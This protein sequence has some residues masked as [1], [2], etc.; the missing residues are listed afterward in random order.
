VTP[1]RAELRAAPLPVE[2]S[3]YDIG[4]AAGTVAGVSQRWS[5]MLVGLDD[6]PG[7]ALFAMEQLGE[8]LRAAGGN[9]SDLQALS[10]EPYLQLRELGKVHGDR[11]NLVEVLGVEHPLAE[12]TAATDRLLSLAGRAVADQFSSPQEGKVVRLGVS[13]G[14]VPKKSTST[15]EIGLRGMADDVQ[16]DRRNHGRPFQAVCLY[17][18]EVIDRLAAEGHPISPGSVGENVTVSGIDWSALR[19]GTRL[20]FTDAGLDEVGG[21]TSLAEPSGPVVEITCWADPCS[22]IAGSFLER[23][24][25]RIQFSDHPGA[26]RAYAAVVVPG[27]VSV[28]SAVRCLP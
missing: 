7:G 5:E 14:G 13:G 3:S 8:V 28:G 10:V 18:L 4:D 26:A 16:A 12:A 25:R 22:T 17:S 27:R 6:V 9:G 15:A 20:A 1:S 11:T 19:A 24:F 21:G 2:V 23:D